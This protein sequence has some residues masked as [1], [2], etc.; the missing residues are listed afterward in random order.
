M[1][2]LGLYSTEVVIGRTSG[3]CAFKGIS[4]DGHARSGCRAM[5]R[6]R[7]GTPRAR[8]RTGAMPGGARS[9]RRSSGQRPARR[10]PRRGREAR[11]V[12]ETAVGGERRGGRA[13]S[14]AQLGQEGVDAR[15][16]RLPRGVERPAIG[17]QERRQVVVV[18][19]QGEAAL[20]AQI[21]GQ[22][23]RGPARSRPSLPSPPRPPHASPPHTL[24]GSMRADRY[25]SVNGAGADPGATFM[26]PPA[27][28]IGRSCP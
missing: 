25:Q 9:L 5:R 6:T 13:R 10:R 19:E 14:A 24:H 16:L 8:W 21:A 11:V 27:L 7:R 17:R 3:T 28:I 22:R 1:R 23:G 15:Q 12:G 26:P 18:L 2:G 20:E 4:A